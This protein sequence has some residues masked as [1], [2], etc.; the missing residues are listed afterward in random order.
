ML[1]FIVTPIIPIIAKTYVNLGMSV[2]IALNYI[3]L[4]F[5]Y[6]LIREFIKR[7]LGIRPLT[8]EEYIN[9]LRIKGI[10]IGGGYNCL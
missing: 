4:Y 1:L 3:T 6:I 8:S 2:T 7:L 10:K 9:N 5:W